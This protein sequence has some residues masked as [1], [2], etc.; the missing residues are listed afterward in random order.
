MLVVCVRGVDTKMPQI[1]CSEGVKP[2]VLKDPFTRLHADLRG[3]SGRHGS[4][5]LDFG[6]QQFNLGGGS[7]VRGSKAVLASGNTGHVWRNEV[8]WRTPATLPEQLGVFELYLTADRG[9]IAAQGD[10]G[11]AGGVVRGASFGGRLV[12]GRFDID[13]SYGRIL[14]TPGGIA[15]P[16]GDFLISA[17]WRF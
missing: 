4:V 2:T 8:F 12:G 15:R 1:L 11:I 17:G 7:S 9:V 3:L 16:D 6:T 10:A 13:A 14:Q 5:S